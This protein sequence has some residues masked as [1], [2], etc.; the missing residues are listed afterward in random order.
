MMSRFAL[1]CCCCCQVEGVMEG[2]IRAGCTAHSGTSDA[3]AV[4]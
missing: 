2:P 1:A 3:F 4:V